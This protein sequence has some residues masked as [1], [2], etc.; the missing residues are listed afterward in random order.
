M[1]LRQLNARVDRITSRQFSGFQSFLN[2]F[3]FE[4]FWKNLNQAKYKDI[5]LLNM[6][7]VLHHHGFTKNATILMR[8][9]EKINPE[10]PVHHFTLGNMFAHLEDYSSAIHHYKQAIDLQPEFIEASQ[11]L[12][13]VL[14]QARGWLAKF[15]VRAISTDIRETKF[16]PFFMLI[17]T[18]KPNFIT[19]W[20]NNMNRSKKRLTNCE[21]SK[22]NKT[23]TV[24]EPIVSKVEWRRRALFGRTMH[25]FKRSMRHRQLRRRRNRDH[26]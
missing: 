8:K 10:Q 26:Q 20:S 11:R 22:I 15:G 18:F 25:N 14:C 6:A 12:F 17:P 19:N 24:N 13:A 3:C 4:A 16:F 5:A 2:H 21:N 1:L 9:A 23:S 7:N